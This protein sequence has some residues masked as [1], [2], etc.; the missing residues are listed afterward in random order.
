MR[1]A[2]TYIKRAAMATRDG[3]TAAAE[4][5]FAIARHRIERAGNILARIPDPRLRS[6]VTKEYAKALVQWNKLSAAS[7]SG[8]LGGLGQANLQP[9]VTPRFLVLGGAAFIG[10][11][12][13]KSTVNVGTMAALAVGAYLF[14][15]KAQEA[16]ELAPLPPPKKPTVF[17]N[18]TNQAQKLMASVR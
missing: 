4:H 12:L 18:I 16:N 2:S 7:G 13:L 10:Y 9:A 15:M 14:Y 5:F 17:A 11:K 1:D 6:A 3:D 8:G